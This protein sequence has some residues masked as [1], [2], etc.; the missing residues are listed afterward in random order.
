[1]RYPSLPRIGLYQPVAGTAVD[2]AWADLGDDVV[3][4]AGGLAALLEDSTGPDRI[5]VLAGLVEAER[6]ASGSDAALDPATDLAAM[7]ERWGDRRL[8]CA[9]SLV[10]AAA[11][12]ECA[13]LD[14]AAAATQ[15]ALAFASDDLERAIGLIAEGR[16]LRYR[17]DLPAARARVTEAITLIGDGDPDALADAHRLQG[18]LLTDVEGSEAAAIL[19]LAVDRHRTSGDLVQLGVALVLLSRTAGGD[20]ERRLRHL[21]EAEQLAL[22]TRAG[23]LEAIVRIDLART[24]LSGATPGQPDWD[25]AARNL[26]RAERLATDPLGRGEVLVLIARQHINEFDPHDRATDLLREAEASYRAMGNR[27][28]LADVARMRARIALIRT[29]QR[30]LSRGGLARQA[31]TD[32]RRAERLYAELGL[33]SWSARARLER[34]LAAAALRERG[35]PTRQ[36]E[37]HLREMEAASD[38]RR[39]AGASVAVAEGLVRRRPTRRRRRLAAGYLDRAEALLAGRPDFFV[40]TSIAFGRAELDRLSDDL[41]AAA[42]QLRAGL[43]LLA[44]VDQH[45][46][47]AVARAR[48][49]DTIRPGVARALRTAALSKAGAEA[50]RILEVRRSARLAGL[51]RRRAAVP[52]TPE[53]LSL[54][55]RL[56]VV[57]E[58]T[59]PVA[60]SSTRLQTPD[61]QWARRQLAE[62]SSELFASYYDTESVDAEA[63]MASIPEH[64]TLV[65][66]DW[67]ED[68]RALIVVTRVPGAEPHV[69]LA[70]LPPGMERYLDLLTTDDDD[71]Q[72]DAE[73]GRIRPADLAPFGTLLGGIANASSLLVVPSGP[74]WAVPWQAVPLPDRRLLIEAADVTLTP[75]LRVHQAVAAE[76]VAVPLQR[77]VLTFRGKGLAGGTQRLPELDVGAE[78]VELHDPHELL[79]MLPTASARFAALLIASHGLAGSGLDH[80]LELGAGTF[81]RAADLLGANLP[82]LVGFGSC[83]GGFTPGDQVDEPIG[84]ATLALCSG[85]RHVIAS[86]T[87]VA[88]LRATSELLADVYTRALD[89]EHPATAV[90]TVM[91]ERFGNRLHRM[92]IMAWAPITTVG[93][94]A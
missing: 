41:P 85:A 58:R 26:E 56:D 76:P 64:V 24:L 63:L 30:G 19:D 36:A 51:L 50:V 65:M 52:L 29:R 55:D 22:R 79:A 57:S 67:L 10:E 28:G 35:L 77:P 17:D 84:L 47:T 59:P 88:D 62:L 11:A 44:D 89:G 80:R 2:Q 13:S 20:L 18:A 3:K 43:D 37:Q 53:I 32:L 49:N 46:D 38:R 93:A 78:R 81:L 90:R 83:F 45:L 34:R 86:V 15:R 1:M 6:R 87:K 21:R 27:R 68:D 7:A 23:S 94:V 40:R 70:G 60:R 75:S 73:R 72:R 92:P 33:G 39:A 5:A 25:E 48:F 16:V 42:S 91:L 14:R 61:Q 69:E 54:L 4:A 9:A 66:L 12:W 74:L 8:N 31:F 82:P 71:H